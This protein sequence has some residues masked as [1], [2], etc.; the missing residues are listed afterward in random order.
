M[1]ADST[2]HHEESA[3]G[4]TNSSN[5]RHAQYILELAPGFWQEGDRD[6]SLAAVEPQLRIRAVRRLRILFKPSM[7]LRFLNHQKSLLTPKK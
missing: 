6:E 1:D 3:R 5:K 4:V 2:H 7:A